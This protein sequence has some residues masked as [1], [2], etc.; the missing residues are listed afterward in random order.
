MILFVSAFQCAAILFVKQHVV[1]DIVGGIAVCEFGIFSMKAAFKLWP[2]I[3]NRFFRRPDTRK[4]AKIKAKV[5]TIPPSLSCD[6][7]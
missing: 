5:K 7:E 3:R 4:D 2:Q 1:L 6:S